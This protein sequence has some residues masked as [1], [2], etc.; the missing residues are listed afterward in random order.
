MTV[1]AVPVPERDLIRVDLHAHTELLTVDEAHRLAAAL[2]LAL[3]RLE[4]PT[5]RPARK[6]ATK[7]GETND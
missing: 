2:R 4:P 5:P 1:N 6:R 3:A 7:N